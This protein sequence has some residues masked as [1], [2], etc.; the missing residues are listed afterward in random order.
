MFPYHHPTCSR[1]TSISVY[2]DKEFLQNDV[3]DVFSTIT[4][5]REIR[6]RET[7][8]LIDPVMSILLTR[9]GFLTWKPF[10]NSEYLFLPFQLR[11]LDLTN[12]DSI[13][14]L[15]DLSL[16]LGGLK[17]WKPSSKHRHTFD[18]MTEKVLKRLIKVEEV[19]YEVAIEMDTRA[20]HDQARELKLIIADC[21]VTFMSSDFS[22]GKYDHF[23]TDIEALRCQV[24]VYT[25]RKVFGRA[26]LIQE[27]LISA[28]VS[29]TQPA[30]Q[31]EAE[32][33]RL[34]KF[35]FDFQDRISRMTLA[36][37][38]PLTQ[39]EGE[40][41]SN[42]C[43]LFRSS[44]LRCPQIF[45]T[46]YGLDWLRRDPKVE[47]ARSLR[48][49]CGR[50]LYH[51]A[52]ILNTSHILQR[53]QLQA[54]DVDEED[55]DGRSAL[56]LA[57]DFGHTVVVDQL[58]RL[59]ADIHKLTEEHQTLLH[60]AA[61]R[62]HSATLRTLLVHLTK[63]YT[64]PSFYTEYP[65]EA[66]RVEFLEKSSHSLENSNMDREL[67]AKLVNQSDGKG[68]SALHTSQNEEC[69][70]ILIEHHADVGLVDNGGSTALHLTRDTDIAKL[71]LLHGANPLSVDSAGRLP[72][73]LAGQRGLQGITKVLLEHDSHTQTATG[74]TQFRARDVNNH[75]T[76]DVIEKQLAQS[77]GQYTS[78]SYALRDAKRQ[79]L[80][81]AAKA[82]VGWEIPD[83]V[84]EREKS[85]AEAATEDC[86]TILHSPHVP[87]ST[88][89]YGGRTSSP[90]S[91]APFTMNVAGYQEDM[92]VLD[93]RLLA[94]GPTKHS[95]TDRK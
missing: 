73:H 10:V 50:T 1:L 52:A 58:L 43:L 80:H 27:R 89:D 29:G 9:G 64:L 11:C 8:K 13:Q 92:N 34:V 74:K 20:D 39:A 45:R 63:H 51:A 14:M 88:E 59:G 83:V 68:R 6:S 65:Y 87:H 30:A 75:T 62:R 49:P 86:G 85:S 33:C 22:A 41:C 31:L 40:L 47:V 66:E 78:K 46:R 76:L 3:F 24:S 28:F 60:I 55:A 37:D 38:S 79:L 2:Q 90:W 36:K 77:E 70:A 71:L 54:G 26:Q 48:Y 17:S 95:R 67:L 5:A 7:K 69:S 72:L 4:I 61:C 18:E 21:P 94:A 56:Q 93:P 57:V 25:T 91:Q 19:L 12:L 32:T 15:E 23:N 81:F 16:V 42:I 82:D 35:Y 53:R 84:Q 44:A